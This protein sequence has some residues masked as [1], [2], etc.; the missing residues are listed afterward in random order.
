MK[1]ENIKENKTSAEENENTKATETAAEESTAANEKK[2]SGNDAIKT[3][4]VLISVK[5]LSKSFGDKE[6]LKDISIDFRKGDVVAIIGP[7]GCGKSTFIRSLN[8]LEEPT[9]GEIFFEGKSI[10][11][12]G[13]DQRKVRE[14]IGMVFQ[15]FN[16]FHN[17]TIKKNL[18]L[19][20]VKLGI[21][22][23][24]E[25]DEKAAQL[26]ERVGLSDKA[27]AYP[28]QLSGGQQQRAAIARSLEMNPDVM[29]F[30]E[31]TS[32]LD[33]EMVN[34]VLNIM[35]ELASD[36]MTMIVV[37]HEIGFAKSAANRVLFI[38]ETRIKEDGTPEEVLDNPKDQ[39]LKSFLAS[40]I[41]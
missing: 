6:V 21:M 36:G 10:T 29:L 19:A 38:D 40:V 12:K 37:T 35:K 14:K 17:M 28:L 7:S 8:L 11:A 3:G 24:E 4:N 1:D 41:K 23:Q 26:L 31:P 34:E 33:P 2:G 32:A 25:A 9:S 15:Q 18:T 39:H 16:L 20:P 22:T 13:T 30:D 27:D 5:N